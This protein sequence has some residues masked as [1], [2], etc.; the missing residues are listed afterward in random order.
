[1]PQIQARQRVDETPQP[2]PADATGSTG[3]SAPRPDFPS[4]TRRHLVYLAGFTLVATILRLYRLGD[5]A[6]W[7]DE[8]HTFRD[9]T[10]PLE[11]WQNDPGSTSSYPLSY[12]LLRVLSWAF[13]LGPENLSEGFLRLPFAIFGVLSVPTLALVARDMIGRKAA[14]LAA[15]FLA[16]SP[17]HIYWSQNARSYAMV[18]FF[19]LLGIGA[20]YH[21]RVRRI[22]W[23]ILA[24]VGCLVVAGLCH[25][26]AYQV[27]FGLLAYLL[28]TWIRHHR[29]AGGL[30][31]WAPLVFFVVLVLLAPLMLDVVQRVAEVKRPEFSFLHLVQTLCYFVGIPILVAAVGGMLLLFDRGAR[32]ASFLASLLI[33]PLIGLAA[34]AA[35]GLFPKLSAQYSFA[36]LPAI[37]IL[38]ATSIMHMVQSFRGI[39]LRPL[40]LRLMAMGVFVFHM[41]GQ[42][43]LY[44][45][46]EFGWRPRWAEAMQYVQTEALRLG[47]D[48][49]TLLTTNEP[50]MSYYADARRLGK[51]RLEVRLEALTSW[52]IRGIEEHPERTPENFIQ[53]LAAA[54]AAEGRGF[55]VV[56]GE[57][58]LDEQ[59]LNGRAKA[60]LRRNFAQVRRLPNWTGPKD[61]VLMV[62]R[63][64]DERVGST[65]RPR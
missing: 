46:R 34:T 56:V 7:V 27:A 61:M 35:S 53:G 6:V 12:Y 55:W 3:A 29:R 10:I 9:V 22:P 58:V 43:Y 39:G 8:A 33:L 26:T 59:D 31:R 5:W 17:W 15:L 18:F 2:A 42:D 11:Q 51:D 48:K 45:A 24:A 36:V 41:L 63:Q 16:V 62:Y 52:R 60:F 30:G 23:M 37:Y 32:P 57:A 38:A 25:P 20:L 28:G 54:A 21:G 64:G 1:M 19:S 50:S 49:I 14:L 13:E 65:R 4:F 40:V 47:Q 44:F